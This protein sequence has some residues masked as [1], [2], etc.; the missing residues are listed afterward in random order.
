MIALLPHYHV[1]FSSAH[2]R[3][4]LVFCELI[5]KQALTAS[6]LNGRLNVP[7]VLQR[8]VFEGD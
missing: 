6:I 3:R 5:P 2:G 1:S 7:A 8:F 4:D